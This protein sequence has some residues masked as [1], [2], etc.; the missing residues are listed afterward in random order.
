MGIILFFFIRGGNRRYGWAFTERGATRFGIGGISSHSLPDLVIGYGSFH[1]R[2]PG[3]AD[4]ERLGV[5][6]RQADEGGADG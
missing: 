5:F 1:D 3:D 6:I 4:Q 2:E